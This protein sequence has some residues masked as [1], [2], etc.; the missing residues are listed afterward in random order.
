MQT[1][2]QERFKAKIRF[3][4]IVML[5]WWLIYSISKKTEVQQKRQGEMWKRQGEMWKRQGEMCAGAGRGVNYILLRKMTIS[6]CL[7]FVSLLSL[8]SLCIG[9]YTYENSCHHIWCLHIQSTTFCLISH[10]FFLWGIT[11]ITAWCLEEHTGVFTNV[12][13]L[14][15]TTFSC[16]MY[17][18]L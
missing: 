16:Y 12:T 1:L 7:G 11:E 10:I 17:A 14:L 3:S 13:R 5:I 18:V 8:C 9:S 4:G 6:V 15:P 2:E